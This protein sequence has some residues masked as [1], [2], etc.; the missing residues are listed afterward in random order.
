MSSDYYI[1]ENNEIKGPYT[2]HQLRAR[3][4]LGLVT[5]ET[6]YYQQDYTMLFPLRDILDKLETDGSVAEH[7]L[8]EAGTAGATEDASERWA[9]A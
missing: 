8:S 1:V 3:W 7:A 5:A 6:L 4:N 2:I 9:V